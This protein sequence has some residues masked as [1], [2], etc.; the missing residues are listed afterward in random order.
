M[1]K[2]LFI[3]IILLCPLMHFL[4]M[5]KHSKNRSENKND[6]HKSCH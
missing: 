4:M 2:Y 3:L 6:D 1:E 5:R